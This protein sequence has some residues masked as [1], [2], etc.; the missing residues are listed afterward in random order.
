MKADVR[1]MVVFN[2]KWE[3]DSPEAKLFLKT[4]EDTFKQIG[5]AKKVMICNE[6]SP[7]NGYDYGFSFDFDTKDDY[8]AY[9]NH[10]LHINFVEKLWMNEVTD[11]LE[12][13]LEEI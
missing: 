12:V 9:N 2:L 10:P 1:H 13:D 8:A 7:K 4:A 5:A 11:F 6:V 3:K